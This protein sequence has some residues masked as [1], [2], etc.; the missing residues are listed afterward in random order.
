MNTIGTPCANPVAITIPFTYNGAGEYCWSTTQAMAYINSWNTDLIEV[1][2]VNFTNQWASN[3]PAAIGGKWYI[4]YKA[5]VSWAHFEAPS[6]KDAGP[7]E[8]DLPHE[9]S[10]YPVPFSNAV[11]INLNGLK[12]LERIELYNAM[13]QLVMSIDGQSLSSEI[14]TLNIDQPGNIFILKIMS[15]Q[16]VITK[17]LIKM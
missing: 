3:M 1:N 9:I 15:S 16:K 5:S 4:H 17:T 8:S 11:F 14:V 6:L 2:G 10:V 13:G 12:N 7:D